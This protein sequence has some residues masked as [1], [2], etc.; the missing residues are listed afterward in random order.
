MRI[1][2][3]VGKDDF[4]SDDLDKYLDHKKFPLD[5]K[6][7]TGKRGDEYV[8][9]DVAIAH[10]LQVLH[11]GTIVDMILPKDVSVNRLSS[12]DVNF[13]LGHDLVDAFWRK[14]GNLRTCGSAWSVA[15]QCKE[16]NPTAKIRQRCVKFSRNQPL[17]RF[18]WRSFADSAA[19]LRTV[20][21]QRRID[22]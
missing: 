5:S 6:Y 3:I 16:S 11:P 15:H 13:I 12:N 22:V 8:S 2:V 20:V 7:L 10:R 19:S 21:D 1:G 14:K 18:M 4:N 17:T 9:S